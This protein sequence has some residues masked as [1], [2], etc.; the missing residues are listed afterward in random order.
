MKL[1]KPCVTTEK[2]RFL[3]WEYVTKN[4]NHHWLY[5]NH[6]DI[7]QRFRECTNCHR[8]EILWGYNSGYEEDWREIK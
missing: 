1:K 8:R 5:E 2:K 7:K 3:F 6:P 4:E